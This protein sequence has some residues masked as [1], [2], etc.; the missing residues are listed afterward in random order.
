M[1]TQ[2]INWIKKLFGKTVNNQD[3]LLNAESSKATYED[4]SGV[5]FTAIFANSLS[6]K[7]VADTTI[8]IEG[9]N[10]RSEFI[11][12]AI[13]KVWAKSL[14]I[15]QQALGK[16]G[17][18]IVPYIQD[19][20][21]QFDIIDQT[22]LMISEQKGDEIT[23]ATILKDTVASGTQTYF[24][25]ADY[26]LDGTN[27]I[28]R[29]RVTNQNGSIF[30]IESFPKW[31]NITEEIVIGNTTKLL[32]AF[33][34]CPTDSRKDKDAYGV[35]ITY[36][37]EAIISETLEH[38]KLIN[39][40]YKLTRPMLG[41]D[42]SMWRD[43]LTKSTVQDQDRPFIPVSS[44]SLD[45][46]APWNLY[47][48]AIRDSAMY[49]RL[50]QLFS[51]MEK[52]VGTSRGILTE[53]VTAA[54]TA[55]EIK[56]SQYDTFTLISAVRKNWETVINDLAYAYDVLAEFYS[57]TPSGQ[58]GQYQVVCNWDWSMF[59]SSQETF[60]QMV[61]LNDKGLLRGAKLNS[62]VTGQTIEEAQEE[63]DFITENEPTLATL[64]GV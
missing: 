42:S 27:H 57:L 23:S 12:D 16:G 2:F 31:Q 9:D 22:R 50:Q 26:S 3:E 55:T 44:E 52:S 1:L 45:G 34:K 49:S 60:N 21:P 32:L 61:T 24:L 41:L 39:R 20:K 37:S 48:P 47:A 15:T 30:S 38:I 19:G 36:G 62:W 54:A 63:I 10:R 14:K 59:E 35:S 53:P 58:R 51:L 5:N 29:H 56:A 28:I 13:S 25:W 33:L 7:T 46:S 11:N 17:K 4:I 18:V 8:T 64:M 43:P 40:E 6:N